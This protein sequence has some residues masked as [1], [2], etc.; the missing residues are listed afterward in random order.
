LF[1][2]IL[3]HLEKVGDGIPPRSRPTTPLTGIMDSV[4]CD[5]LSNA[6]IGNC[7]RFRLKSEKEQ[8]RKKEKQKEKTVSAVNTSSER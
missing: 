5:R 1:S 7:N 8:K 6:E 4:H 2:R 3:V